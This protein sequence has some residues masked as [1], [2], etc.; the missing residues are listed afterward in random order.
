[1]PTKYWALYVANYISKYCSKIS[2]KLKA[3]P[4]V[5]FVVLNFYHLC[6]NH[7]CLPELDAR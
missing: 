4:N 2:A 5:E 7:L 1:M 6:L 3:M